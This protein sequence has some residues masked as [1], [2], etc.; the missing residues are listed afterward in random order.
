MAPRSLRKTFLVCKMNKRLEED[1]HVKGI[2]KEFAIILSKVGALR[3]GQGS[4]VR[5]KPD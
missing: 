4:R 5:K 3:K 2:E 1:L